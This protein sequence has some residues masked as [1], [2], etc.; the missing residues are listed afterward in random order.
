MVTM[1]RIL[2][3]AL[4]ATGVWLLS[5]LTT[6][7]GLKAAAGV[8]VLAS[9]AAG[10]LYLGHAV[11]DGAG[12]RA[13]LWMA[14]AAIAA[15]MVPGWLGEA[16]GGGREINGNAGTGVLDKLW[17][18]FNEATLAKLVRE[19]NTVFVDVTAEWC[20]TCQINKAFVLNKK[21]VLAALR[22][23]KVVA[24]QADWTRPDPMISDFLARNQRYG[25]PF[26]AVYGPGAPTGIVLPEL[27][28]QDKVLDAFKQAARK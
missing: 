17:T 6:S 26:D 5:V 19:G 4:A 27:L 8:G 9:A 10:L 20:L 18:P 2:G 14:V 16:S 13:P 23:D 24:M 28:S 12:R 15:F 7:I 3:F 21:N 11:P 22:R 1:K 25:I